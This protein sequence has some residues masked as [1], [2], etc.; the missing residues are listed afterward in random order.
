MM[1]MPSGVEEYE[2]GK[3]KLII[4][5]VEGIFLFKHLVRYFISVRRSDE[6]RED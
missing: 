1:S 5:E 3:K 2:N 6:T 4:H